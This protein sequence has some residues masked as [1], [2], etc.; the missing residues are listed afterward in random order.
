MASSSA[1]ASFGSTIR[2]T[3]P[4]EPDTIRPYNQSVHRLEAQK[5]QIHAVASQAE[6]RLQ[7][8]GRQQWSSLHSSPTRRRRSRSI[9]PRAAMTACPVPRG[10]SCTASATSPSLATTRSRTAAGP[11]AN[12]HDDPFTA[13]GLD[14]VDHAVQQGS[15]TDLV[16][17]LRQ[18]GFHPRALAGGEDYGGA[19]CHR[20]HPWGRVIILAARLTKP[21]RRGREAASVA[22]FP[23]E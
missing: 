22:A 1:L 3:L 20:G 19:G 13:G 17:H 18:C 16:K 6:Q 21:W 4:S 9:A 8:A 11:S 15:A 10:G 5:R 2:L 23:G 12:H 14:G 7:I